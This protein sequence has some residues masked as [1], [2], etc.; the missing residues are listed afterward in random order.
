MTFLTPGVICLFLAK[1]IKTSAVIRDL[2]WAEIKIRSDV[3]VGYCGQRNADSC[4]QMWPS[5]NLLLLHL[6]ISLWF[7]AVSVDDIYLGYNTLSLIT[8]FCTI[9]PS[10]FFNRLL[11]CIRLRV[12]LFASPKI[13]LVYYEYFIQRNFC[14]QYVFVFIFLLSR[15]RILTFLWKV[16][17]W[18]FLFFIFFFCHRSLLYFVMDIIYYR[19]ITLL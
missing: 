1:R 4:A 5:R 7:L 13:V 6:Y 2:A 15:V 3:I 18:H 14:L 19:Y 10:F 8:G 9:T 12:F 17:T 16:K 11:L